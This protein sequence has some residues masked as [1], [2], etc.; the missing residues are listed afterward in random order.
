VDRDRDQSYFLFDLSQEQLAAAVFPLGE[1]RK[2]EVRDLARQLELPVAEKP[3]SRDLCFVAGGSYRDVL[4]RDAPAA[5]ESGEVVD[6]AGKV[7]GRHAGVSNFTVGQRRGLGVASGRRLY[8][9]SLVPGSRRVVVG[10][11]D[12]QYCSSLTA[13]RA[14]WIFEETPSGP[15]EASVRVRYRHAGAPG[16]V[17]PAPDGEFRVEFEEPQ[18]AVSPGQ[19]VV[20]YRDEEVL[21]GGWID[22]TA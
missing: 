9:L 2:E 16:R 15:F 7:L 20:L 19:A 13:R 3:E 17:I 10:E 1:L 18:R 14:N 11:E 21:G 4:E 22:S 12:E 8:V 6:R 5:D